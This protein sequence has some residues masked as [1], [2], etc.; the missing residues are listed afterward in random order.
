MSVRAIKQSFHYVYDPLV[1]A[2]L[3]RLAKNSKKVHL[4]TDFDDTLTDVRQGQKKHVTTFSILNNYLPPEAHRE[5]K[6]MYEKYRPLEVA[7]KMTLHQAQKWWEDTLRLYK[8]YRINIRDIE[9][10]LFLRATSR[11]GVR[12][13]FFTCK[14]HH[15]PT[16]ILSGGVTDIISLWC[17]VFDIQPNLIVSNKF[18]F[19]EQ[20]YV[21]GWSDKDLIHSHNK[22]E[23]AHKQ[24]TPIRN[25]YPF[26]ILLGDSLKDAEM[27]EGEENVLRIRII[28]RHSEEYYNRE[29]LMANTFPKFDMLIDTGNLKPLTLL[30]NELFSRER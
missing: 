29:Q 5:E 3:D 14:A 1:Y 20:G 27:V 17:K 26:T 6:L 24:I 8:K 22:K 11:E 18:F 30:I 25:E 15:I 28:D 10:E 21:V 2:K 7:H 19:D 4:V 23:Q 9:R 12:E 13:L 16:V